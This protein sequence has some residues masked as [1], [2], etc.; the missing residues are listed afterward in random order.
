MVNEHLK[1]INQIPE[2]LP[3]AYYCLRWLFI[4]IQRLIYLIRKD[5][6]R[7]RDVE[8]SV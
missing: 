8:P 6:H 4:R 5:N 7:H 2:Y 1:C 3:I